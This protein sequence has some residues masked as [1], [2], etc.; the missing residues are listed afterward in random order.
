MEDALHMNGS[1]KLNG[2]SSN[3]INGGYDHDEIDSGNRDFQKTG[4]TIKD[5]KATSGPETNEAANAG[6]QNGTL[7]KIPGE[8]GTPPELISTMASHMV[9]APVA[10]PTLEETPVEQVK[11]SEQPKGADATEQQGSEAKEVN[12]SNGT[13]I[14]IKGDGS[15]PDVAQVEVM[16]L[17]EGPEHEAQTD[18]S[19]VDQPETVTRAGTNNIKLFLL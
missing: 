8:S 12:A 11:E 17:I 3:G 2:E 5:L 9:V 16:V 15:S 13:E 14:H 4:E 1:A 7:D 18:L 10:S 6:D 19:A